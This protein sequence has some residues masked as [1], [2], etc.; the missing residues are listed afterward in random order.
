MRNYFLGKLSIINYRMAIHPGDAL[1]RLESQAV[2]IS[3]K[4]FLSE[5]PK[6]YEKDFAKLI[7]LCEKTLDN[8]SMGIQNSTA[9]KYLKL[10][11]EIEDFLENK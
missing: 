10:L 2:E 5:A 3:H 4:L 11:I 6:K 8:R 7:T 1:R 9:S